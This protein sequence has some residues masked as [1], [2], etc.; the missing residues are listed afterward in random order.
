MRIIYTSDIHSYLFPTTYYE[1]GERNV[2]LMRICESFEKDPDT[3]V[4]DGGDTI[5]GS[6]LSKFVFDKGMRPF[7]QATVFRLM[8]LD[9]A[10]PGNHDFN[11]GYDAFREFF[12]ET[13]AV[14][15]CA[16]LEDR[17][18]RLDIR[19]HVI[20]EDSKGLRVGFVGAVT[21]YVNVW[22]RPENLAN[23]E[24]KP[25]FQ[26]VSDELGRIK[27]LVDY[28]VLV[29]HGGFERDPKDGRLLSS[30]SEN[31]AYR[32]CT[33]LSFDLVL[34]AHQ[35]MAMP[36][37][38]VGRSYSMQCPANGAMY[39]E[40]ILGRD[41]VSGAL[42]TADEHCAHVL[43]NRFKALDDDVQRWLD[44]TVCTIQSPI[45]APSVIDSALK[46]SRIADFFNHVQLETT[47]AD[48]SCTS[49]ANKLYGFDREITIR[50]VIASYQ[51]PNT[52][53]V[54]EVGE[55]ALRDAL[56][57]C[58]QFF[59]IGDEGPQISRAFLEP[60]VEMYNYDYYMGIE[61][62]FDIRRPVGERVTK[63]L[64]KGEPIGDRRLRLCLNNYRA[65]GTGGYDVF[66]HQRVLKVYSLDVQD[67]AVSYL[68]AH[69]ENLVW[70]SAD[71]RTVY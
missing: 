42:K 35:H 47:H 8:G 19:K 40:V 21:D 54:I 1:R 59:T 22:E 9:I 36:F 65:S 60:K 58:A 44:R 18:G 26:S 57:R 53:E 49:L 2:G 46:G 14:L 33:E 6:A 71:F 29:Y 27:D 50:Q 15:L 10:V 20:M 70:P 55:D 13:G 45:P 56:E 63:L 3:V 7:P 51:F 5:Q 32:I 61:Y 12:H 17:T 30:T 62:E 38:K 39:A 48:V 4:V 66:R 43:E 34:T 64:F 25:V 41:G 31:E 16:N 67:L 68:L 11:Y 24:V 23:F 69:R 52:I 37:A 28:T